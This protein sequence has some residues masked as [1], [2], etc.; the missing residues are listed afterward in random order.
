MT[1]LNFSKNDDFIIMVMRQS[2]HV[3]F[4]CLI[5]GKNFLIKIVE[6]NKIDI[7]L[8]HVWLCKGLL[9]PAVLEKL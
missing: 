1:V 6:N 8:E 4:S 5:S 2:F 3:N 9:C 7:Y